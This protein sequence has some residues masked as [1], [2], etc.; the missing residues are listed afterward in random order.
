[1]ASELVYVDR[2]VV[3]WRRALR[4]RASIEHA[5][6]VGILQ[7][8]ISSTGKPVLTRILR[9]G[10]V[11][12]RVEDAIFL[13]IL[14][15]SIAVLR[16][17]G[18]IRTPATLSTLGPD[19]RE[20][21]RTRVAQEFASLRPLGYDAA[22]NDL[23]FDART[24]GFPDERAVVAIDLARATVDARIPLPGRGLEEPRAL[25]RGGAIL[26]EQ[27]GMFGMHERYTL[28]T[29]TTTRDLATPDFLPAHVSPVA[30]WSASGRA[31]LVES[32]TSLHRVEDDGRVA[33]QVPAPRGV[34]RVVLTGE[35]CGVETDAG[36]RASLDCRSV[37][38]GRTRNVA[39]NLGMHVETAFGDGA[40]VHFAGRTAAGWRFATA[41][42]AGD[43]VAA[44]DVT[45]EGFA[46]VAGSSPIG[47]VHLHVQNRA[48][49]AY[50]RLGERRWSLDA[51]TLGGHVGEVLGAR[52][53]G[54]LVRFAYDRTFKPGIAR[55]ERDGRVRWRI[56]AAG[57]TQLDAAGEDWLLSTDEAGIER[58]ADRDGAL[59]WRS[60]PAAGFRVVVAVAPDGRTFAAGPCCAQSS[61][62]GRYAGDVWW[63]DTA[64]GARIGALPSAD[65]PPDDHQARPRFAFDEA[66]RL[67]R[68]HAELDAT[69]GRLVVE[70]HALRTAPGTSLARTHARGL[71][72]ASMLDGQALHVSV[73]SRGNVDGRW[74]T[75]SLTRANDPREQR[76]FRLTGSARGERL[77]LV[78][79][80]PLDAGFAGGDAGYRRVGTA[81]WRQLECARAE[82]EYRFTGTLGDVSGRAILER[83]D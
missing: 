20:R 59:A 17:V 23:V 22:G 67:V 24:A 42:A 4:T 58:R 36:Q 60:E 49:V 46:F 10:R 31:V 9:D 72:R 73:D 6:A 56:E 55:I 66:G 38:T 44:R 62:F 61:P 8:E 79:E 27:V 54:A 7:G 37:S 47:D 48:T 71:W 75:F 51:A 28:R 39:L 41:T 65:S 19:G 18:A 45:T 34:R 83:A 5:D 57:Y 52:D 40:H 69:T 80:A 53:G 68:V 26:V 43:V 3:H 63:H 70:R 12:W 64:T 14:P 15:D 11:A 33:W 35:V 1:M 13:A 50:D 30:V 2:S 82:I 25:L 29:P 21:S 74:F 77:E 81:H 32:R 16:D 78:I 76:W